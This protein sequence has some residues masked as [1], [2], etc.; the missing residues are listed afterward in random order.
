MEVARAELADQAQ[1]RRMNAGSA[2]SLDTGPTSAEPH[3][4]R[5]EMEEGTGEEVTHATDPDL[6]Q[7]PEEA[8][9]VIQETTIG[10][11]ESVLVARKRVTSE[12]I[13]PTKEVAGKHPVSLIGEETTECRPMEARADLVMR[14]VEG[15]RQEAGHQRKDVR[16]EGTTEITHPG[17]PHALDLP[18]VISREITVEALPAATTTEPVLT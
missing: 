8:A 12:P 15:S 18:L 2:A 11:K 5:T 1:L 14:L 17:T 16:P 13:A 7:E 10:E 6:T 4:V 9:E 3:A